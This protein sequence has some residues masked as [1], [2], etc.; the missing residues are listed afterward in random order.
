MGRDVVELDL[1][2]S[3]DICGWLGMALQVSLGIPGW[4]R[5]C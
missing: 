3:A 5:K 2:L 1:G 4:L